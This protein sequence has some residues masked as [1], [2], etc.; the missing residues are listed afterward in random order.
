[1]KI[2]NAVIIVTEAIELDASELPD[3]AGSV[4]LARSDLSADV[5]D[6]ALRTALADQHARSP[7][8]GAN[9]GHETVLSRVGGELA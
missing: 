4:I 9:V 6:L 7:Q 2:R 1:M 8:A 5:F 3:I